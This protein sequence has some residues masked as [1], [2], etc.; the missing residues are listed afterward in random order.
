MPQVRAFLPLRASFSVQSQREILRNKNEADMHTLGCN[1]VPFASA[2]ASASMHVVARHWPL[3]CG[4][5]VAKGTPEAVVVLFAA[6]AGGITLAINTATR[7]ANRLWSFIRVCKF[8]SLAHL[9]ALSCSLSLAR[10]L[11]LEHQLG[12][13]NER[14]LTVSEISSRLS[15][16]CHS[17]RHRD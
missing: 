17:R 12:V 15:N 4:R 10:S 8:E 6:R 1:A 11:F 5:G 13:L 3:Y 7:L 16:H 14:L 9:L 2:P